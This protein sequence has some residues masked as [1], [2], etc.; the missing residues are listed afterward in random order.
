MWEGVVS[1]GQSREPRT[2]QE[3]IADEGGG[4]QDAVVEG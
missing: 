4:G 1:M 2:T 3:A